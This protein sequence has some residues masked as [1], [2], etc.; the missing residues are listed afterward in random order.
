MSYDVDA[1]LNLHIIRG[2]PFLHMVFSNLHKVQI[3]TDPRT[4]QFA[5]IREENTYAWGET[6]IYFN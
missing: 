5:Q 6:M 3:R 1:L 4:P 2:R